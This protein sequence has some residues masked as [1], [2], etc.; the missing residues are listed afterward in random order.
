MHLLVDACFQEID[1][2]DGPFGPSKKAVCDVCEGTGSDLVRFVM[3]QVCK[4]I[5]G[6]R[7]VII[8]INIDVACYLYR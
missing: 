3:R 2:P 5:L 4:E 1:K 8:V 6:M 7:L